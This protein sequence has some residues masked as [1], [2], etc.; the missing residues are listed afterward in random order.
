MGPREALEL[1]AAYYR[2]PE[3]AEDLLER[4]ELTSVATTPW[5]RLSGGEQQRISLALALVGRPEIVFLDEP[6]AGVDPQGRVSIR[7]EISRLR[8]AGRR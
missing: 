2:R 3:S 1:F 6:T 5:K 4:L 7:Q 8:E